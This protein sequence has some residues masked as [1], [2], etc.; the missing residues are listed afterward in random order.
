M[1]ID[2]R[3]MTPPTAGRSSVL[4]VTGVATTER[5]EDAVRSRPATDPG[6]AAGGGSG[7][8]TPKAD[9]RSHCALLGRVKP[10]PAPC[11]PRGEHGRHG[12]SRR[13][14]RATYRHQSPTPSS[15]WKVNG[16][17]VM[18][19]FADPGN[20]DEPKMHMMPALQLFGAARKADLRRAAL[21]P[22][23]EFPIS[24]TIPLPCRSG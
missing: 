15:W 10:K 20:S 2:R 11:T 14:R 17:Y 24:T 19:S 7:S 12:S 23:G 4:S 21:Y 18:D 8:L 5:T 6:D 22:G 3:R 9:P 1:R 16:R 13:Y